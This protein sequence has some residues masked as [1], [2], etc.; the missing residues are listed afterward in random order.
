MYY[1]QTGSVSTKTGEWDI[2]EKDLFDT[3]TVPYVQERHFAG[4]SVEDHS[5]KKNSDRENGEMLNGKSQT[6]VS[7]K[8][9]GNHS[10]ISHR[11][12]CHII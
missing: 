11:Y 7:K 2:H 10:D 4:W 1:I 9:F 5:E 3:P 8:L 12:C 6:K